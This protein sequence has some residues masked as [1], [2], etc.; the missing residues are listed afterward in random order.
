MTQEETAIL[1]FLTGSQEEYYGRK[2]IARKAVHRSEYEANPHWVDA[3]L[4]SLLVQGMLEQ[5]DS[6]QYRIRRSG[7]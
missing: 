2:E 6:G 4:A 3:P 5:N 1:Q 7:L